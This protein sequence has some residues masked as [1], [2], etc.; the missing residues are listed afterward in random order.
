MT[1]DFFIKSYDFSNFE[2]KKVIL[3]N[4][5]LKVYV[6]INAHLDLIANG[7][8]PELDVDYDT[9]FCFDVSKENDII[10][11]KSFFKC[12]KNN[13][14]YIEIGNKKYELT[15]DFVEIIK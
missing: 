7:Y 15:N 3:K 14:Y 4:Y 2:I 9:I 10:K 12:Y 8:R 11:D 1:L 6:T 13:I 5:K